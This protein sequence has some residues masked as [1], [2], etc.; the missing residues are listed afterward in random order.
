MWELNDNRV[1]DVQ[2]VMEDGGD[3]WDFEG[4]LAAEKV[5]ASKVCSKLQDA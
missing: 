2:D 4:M 1:S 5:A 3:S